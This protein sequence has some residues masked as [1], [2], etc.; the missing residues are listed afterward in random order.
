MKGAA[1]AVAT[2]L[3]CGLLLTISLGTGGE[4]EKGS[5]A[6]ERAAVGVEL[7]KAT[8]G[9]G[10]AVLRTTW[11]NHSEERVWLSSMLTPLEGI[12]GNIL[13]FEPPVQYVGMLAKRMYPPPPETFLLL[14]AG[15]HLTADILISEVQRSYAVTQGTTYEVSLGSAPLLH[16][17]AQS[18]PSDTSAL[19]EVLLSSRLPSNAVAISF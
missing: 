12:R 14:D 9:E 2:V 1:A 4:E 16:V 15:G 11:T 8:D 7:A 6:R 18:L 19:Q 13:T 3:L 5:A 17:F 10:R